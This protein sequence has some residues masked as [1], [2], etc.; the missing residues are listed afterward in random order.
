MLENCRWYYWR[1]IPIGADG[2]PGT[3]SSVGSFFVQT[4]RTC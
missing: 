1:V 4:T 3:P 2:D